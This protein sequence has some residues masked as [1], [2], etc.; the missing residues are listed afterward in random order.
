MKIHLMVTNNR[1]K[2]VFSSL[3][4]LAVKSTWPPYFFSLDF[5]ISI[6]VKEKSLCVAQVSLIWTHESLHLASMIL[7]HSEYILCRHVLMLTFTSGHTKESFI[8][9]L[10]TKMEKK[11]LNLLQK[12]ILM[13]FI[14]LNT[15]NICSMKLLSILRGNSAIRVKWLKMAP[16]Q[17]DIWLSKWALI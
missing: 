14:F 8:S 2:R 7:T 17:T 15:I 12:V 16:R 1:V 6:V 11:K 3:T 10:P 5:W 13:V 4:C 9:V